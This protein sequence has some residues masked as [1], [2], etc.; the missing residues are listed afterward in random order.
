MES[1]VSNCSESKI[2]NLTFFAV[3]RLRGDVARES[4]ERI[5]NLEEM[6]NSISVVK[7]YCWESFIVKKIIQFR[8]NETHFL[9]W[10]AFYQGLAKT[11]P[12]FSPHLVLISTILA[13]TY[14]G[15]GYLR[16][17]D[18][19]LV[20]TLSNVLNVYTKLT[21]MML[22][23]FVEMFSVNQRVKEVLLLPEGP[24]KQKSDIKNVIISN[25]SARYP[26]AES[27]TLNRIS[28]NLEE[29]MLMGVIGSVG[30]G[31]GIE[32]LI[33]FLNSYSIQ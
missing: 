3:G 12:I 13:H 30:A 17:S 32:K 25:L 31:K 8:R 5:S 15:N 22:Y 29:G 33:F 19:F 16:A 4:D 24:I 2:F 10:R 6:I 1:E 28:L 20:M 21:I 23:D 11:F 26:N 7:M 27:N 18:I 14:M 9:K